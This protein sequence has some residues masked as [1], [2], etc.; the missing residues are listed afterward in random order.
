MREFVVVTG[1][2]GGIGRALLDSLASNGYGVIAVDK[3]RPASDSPAHWLTFDLAR[4]ANEGAAAEELRAGIDDILANAGDARLV[5]LV[6]NA[7]TQVVG[8]AA[9]MPLTDI[10][11]SLDVNVVAP[12][13]LSQL[14]RAC[15]AKHRGC[16][17]NI[18]SIHSRLT[19]PGFA[20]YSVSKSALAGLSRA[21]A[22]EWGADIRIATIEPAAIATP[23]LESGFEGRSAERAELDRAHPAGTIGQPSQVAHWLL[24]ILADRHSFANGITIRLDG[25]IGSRLHDPV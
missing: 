23:M 24:A 21:L 22:V 18:G 19:K 16:I 12:W 6:N 14:L 13:V 17:V 8:D 20:A 10:R 25:G 3:R 2:D 1:A 5:A 7:A 4:L 11:L 15:L 9:S